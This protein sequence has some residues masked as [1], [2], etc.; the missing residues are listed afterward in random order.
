MIEGKTKSG[1]EYKIEDTAFNDMRV[2]DLLIDMD[3]KDAGD[4][5][6]I[7]SKVS[8]L[9]LGEQQKNELYKHIANED[10]SVGMDKFMDEMADILTSKPELKN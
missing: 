2:I 4:A 10:G 7:M 5:I 6:I 8:R 9:L 1:F 3:N